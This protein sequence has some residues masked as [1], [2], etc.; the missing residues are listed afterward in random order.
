VA[1]IGTLEA[2]FGDAVAAIDAGDVALLERLL[3]A[4][5]RL[6][7][8]RA[9]AGE[10]YFRRP[11]L[12]WFVAENPIRTG[13]LPPNVVDVTRALLQALEREGVDSRREQADSTMALVCSGRIAR[14]CGVQR[15]LIDLLAAAGADPDGALLP[16]LAHREVEA[17]RRLLDLGAR[18]TLTAAVCLGRSAD[19]AHLGEAAGEEEKQRA[20]AAAAL[21]GLPAALSLLIALGVDVNAFSPAGFHPHAT[22]LHH[23]VD[24]GSLEAVK[25]LVEAGA[26]L[27]TKDHVHQGTP[28]DWA[29]Y[30]GRDAIAACLRGQGKE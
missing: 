8:D 13:A 17:A 3:A 5:P 19:A 20:L 11:Y 7:R 16:A 29:E 4:H 10:G 1:E 9:D 25:V 28:L 18:M 23:A 2:P 27:D 21:Y 22:A 6:L 12:L 14:E 24:S 15:G 30:M 26:A